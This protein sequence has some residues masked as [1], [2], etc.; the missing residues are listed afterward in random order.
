MSKQDEIDMEIARIS[1]GIHALYN[2]LEGVRGE[3]FAH[4]A[5]EMESARD[6]FSALLDRIERS[7]QEAA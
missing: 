3:T 5:S 2:R 6:R 7:Q 1:A 4:M